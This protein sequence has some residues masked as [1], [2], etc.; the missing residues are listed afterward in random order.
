MGFTRGLRRTL[1]CR[2]TPA[3]RVEVAGK[4]WRAKPS[5]LRGP[6]AHVGKFIR[7]PFMDESVSEICP[8]RKGSLR[9]FLILVLSIRQHLRRRGG[10]VARD[11]KTFERN[12]R[13][14]SR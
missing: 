5:K 12:A 8:S 3:Y 13:E 11:P 10:A 9:F 14:P 4:G 1:H 2:R 6:V 7:Q